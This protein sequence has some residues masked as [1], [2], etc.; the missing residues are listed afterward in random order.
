MG[1]AQRALRCSLNLGKMMG[2]ALRAFDIRRHRMCGVDV[3]QTGRRTKRLG[4]EVF[5]ASVG[6]EMMRFAVEWLMVV[7]LAAGFAIAAR[8]EEVDIGKAEF[9]SSCASC[10]G[11]DAKG[12]GPVSGQ[13]KT[14]PSDLT[15]LARN[16]SGVFPTNAVYETVYGSK[17][18]P[19][20][21]TREMPIWGER[22][23]PIINLP[24]AVDPYY[25]QKAGPQQNPEVV[26]RTR[27][28]AVIDYLNRIQQK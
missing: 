3:G 25:W 5:P 23:N 8:A 7:G 9:Q 6:G 2:K 27:I 15:M 24:H 17:S 18:V 26:V 19:A 12:N 21:G 22:F 20:H 14:T 4:A 28:L 1:K 10:H 11:A 13:L 16:N